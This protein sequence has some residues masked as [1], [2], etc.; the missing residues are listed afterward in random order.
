L[1]VAAHSDS[2]ATVRGG[3]KPKTNP[4]RK[5]KRATSGCRV[6]F[7]LATGE[8][9]RAILL[10]P[11]DADGYAARGSILVYTGHP[12]EA[13]ESFDIAKRLNPNLGS[14]GLEPVGWAYYL[15]R[16][17]EEAITVF[18][19]GLRTS[20]DDYFVYAGLAASYA[21][22]DRK[23]EASHAADDLRR[24]W[25]FFETGRFVEQFEGDANRALI[26]EGLH[27]SGLN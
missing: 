15:E 14:G 4:S 7:D 20:P 1:T 27:T 22:L 19:A 10:N 2:R 21:Q 26:R 23:D 13:I 25:P 9:D 17:Y 24:V 3:A 8:Y 5:K 12:E 11:N 6:Q 18:N 16:R